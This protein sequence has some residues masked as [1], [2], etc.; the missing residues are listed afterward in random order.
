MLTVQNIRNYK[1]FYDVLMYHINNDL[2]TYNENKEIV[3]I[4]TYGYTD[5]IYMKSGIECMKYSVEL[6]YHSSEIETF[7]YVYGIVMSKSVKEV[8]KTKW[9]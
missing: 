1:D 4:R 2:V 7:V 9:K 3:K 6:E 8:Y 5:Y